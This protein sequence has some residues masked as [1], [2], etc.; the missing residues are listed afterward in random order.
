MRLNAVR[1]AVPARCSRG[2]LAGRL[3]PPNP[4][5]SA[6]DADPKTLGRR[7]AR[8]APFYYSAHNTFAKI[9][10][11]CHHP[12]PPSRGEHQESQTDM[13]RESPRFSSMDDRSSCRCGVAG[14]SRVALPDLPA[15]GP[16]AKCH[17]PHSSQLCRGGAPLAADGPAHIAEEGC[18]QRSCCAWIR[19]Q[20]SECSVCAS[21]SSIISDLAIYRRRHS[22]VCRGKSWRG[23]GVR[24]G[25]RS[26]ADRWRG[27]D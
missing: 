26:R 7:I 10:R 21:T 14:S 15:F 13:I 25:T 27:C 17:A 6:G 2:D 16:A 9:V 19:C 23:Y 12:P 18:T 24:E 5:Y 22:A 8:H 1:P 11:K 3:E 20:L 4:A